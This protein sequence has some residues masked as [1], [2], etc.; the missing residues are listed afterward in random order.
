MSLSAFES[1][2]QDWTKTNWCPQALSLHFEHRKDFFAAIEKLWSSQNYSL[3]SG[4]KRF[5]PQLVFAV[6][7]SLNLPLEKF[8]PWALAVEM[9]HTYS[10]IHDDL[11]AMDNDD[12]RR[13]LP[14]NH[15]VYGEAA[16]LL[17]GDSLLTEA[18]GLLA[19]EYKHNAEQAVEL[20]Q[21]LSDSAG[22]RG[23]V[24]GQ[25]W[26]LFS[27]I[28]LNKNEI[29]ELHYYKTGALIRASIEG[30][31]V[32]SQLS[33]EDRSH[34]RNFAEL[35]GVAFQIQDDILDYNQKD[36]DLKNLAQRFG[37]DST[38]NLLIEVSQAAQKEIDKLALSGISNWTPLTDLIRKNQLRQL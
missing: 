11:P 17:A 20:I 28:E 24:G 26:D 8:Y 2:V 9:I 22:P 27:E 3:S 25:A 5:R 12:V 7:E 14:T 36:E 30:A 32:L 33:A 35:I 1:Y 37:L 21:I 10:L 13:G 29:L 6:A 34:L 4:G 15:K 23:M 31:A 18:F 38:K 16:A 19:N